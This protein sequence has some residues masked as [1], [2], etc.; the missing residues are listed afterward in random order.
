MTS[1]SDSLAG[2]SPPAVPGTRDDSVAVQ[3]CAAAS[4]G[5]RTVGSLSIRPR[6]EDAQKWPWGAPVALFSGTRGAETPTRRQGC[7]RFVDDMASYRSSRAGEQHPVDYQKA[8]TWAALDAAFRPLRE[9]HAGVVA[10]MQC[11]VTRTRCTG[12]GRCLYSLAPCRCSH[13]SVVKVERRHAQARQWRKWQ[14][15]Q[16]VLDER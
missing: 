9:R 14:T 6:S 13:P 7:R 15:R 5:T 12:Y 1:S 3:G 2:L 11:P 10:P 16:E 4:P 8:S